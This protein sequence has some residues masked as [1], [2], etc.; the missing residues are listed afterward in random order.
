MVKV[1][2]HFRRWIA[3]ADII[4]FVEIQIMSFDLNRFVI[5]DDQ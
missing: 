2:H 4:R 5:D 3:S 1:V